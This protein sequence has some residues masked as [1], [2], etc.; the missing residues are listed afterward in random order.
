MRFKVLVGTSLKM[1][2]SG[3]IHCV[4]CDEGSKLLEMS[5]SIYQTTWYNIPEDCHLQA[6]RK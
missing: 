4:V 1:A 6:C 5:V 2:S 3:M